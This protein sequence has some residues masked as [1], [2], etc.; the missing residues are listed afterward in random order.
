MQN[1]K[2]MSCSLISSYQILGGN[3]TADIFRAKEIKGTENWDRDTE[4][5]GFDIT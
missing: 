3:P 2:I 4:D 5:L 1:I